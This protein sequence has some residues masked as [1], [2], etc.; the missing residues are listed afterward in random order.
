MRLEGVTGTG[1][2]GTRML[3]LTEDSQEF[4]FTGL[5]E[6]P[7]LSLNRGF[8]APIILDAGLTRDERLFLA[9]HD[10]DPFNRWDAL[11]GLLIDAVR[12]ETRARL[13]HEPG[14][15]DPKLLET[16]GAVLKD[17]SL[18]PAF[19]A[20][21]LAMPTEK[22]VADTLP[23][24]DPHAVHSAWV[25]VRNA[26]AKRNLSAFMDAAEK[27]AT[28]GPYDPSAEPAGKRAL[29]NLALSY[30]IAAGNARATILV[31]DQFTTGTNLSD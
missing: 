12:K 2:V 22:I 23:V 30:A 8:A 1:I 27:S 31:K 18:S 20:V 5:A 17:E 14:D 15:I 24:I 16:V 6:K 29:K 10:C 11:N 21:A 7:V 4:V 19:K 3:E 28:P 13:L 26:I 25:A 9:A